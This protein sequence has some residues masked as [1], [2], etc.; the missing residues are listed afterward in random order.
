MAYF[1]SFALLM[2]FYAY[3]W[4]TYGIRFAIGATTVAS[5][6]AP[7][8]LIAPLLGLPI[9]TRIASALVCLLTVCFTGSVFFRRGILPYGFVNADFCLIAMVGIHCL[10]DWI[11]GGSFLIVPI[12]AYGEWL[13]PYF[14]GR[15]CVMETADLRRLAAVATAVLAIIALL[16]VA[17]TL[18]EINL[19]EVLVGKRPPDLA[20]TI[21]DRFGF[22]RAYGPT[23]HS[24]YLGVLIL[25]LLPW[26]SLRW[27]LPSGWLNKG[28]VAFT[29]VTSAAALVMTG[30]RMAILGTASALAVASFCFFTRLRWAIAVAVVVVLMATWWFSD[31]LFKY[32]MRV[33]GESRSLVHHTIVIDGKKLPY[34][35]AMCRIYILRLYRPAL[36]Q[37]GLLGYGTERTDGFPVRVPINEGNE[38]ALEMMPAVDNAYLL[39]ALRFG[40]LGVSALIATLAC[41]VVNAFIASQ[42]IRAQAERAFAASLCGALLG[43][44]I[45]CA[46]V[47]MPYDFGFLLLWTGGVATSLRYAVDRKSVPTPALQ[48]T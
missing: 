22:K 16:S 21:A 40:W 35:S 28:S 1:F 41:F 33:S 36:Q 4:R 26:L 13:V 27:L 38:E 3:S 18:L 25:L 5:L 10:S 29:A 43:T 15:F 24:M 7:T 44:A 14:L 6:L 45:V 8:W 19:F 31:P 9:D 46:T 30:S 37:T 2:A 39:M 47:W 23:T 34:S 48:K 42:H 17:E 12:R 32:A 20:P 11:A